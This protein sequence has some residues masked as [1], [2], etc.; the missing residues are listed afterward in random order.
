MKTKKILASSFFAAG[1]AAAFAQYSSPELILVT[2]LGGYDS[3]NTFHA[4]KIDRYDPSTGSYLGSFGNFAN[5]SPTAIT[6]IG[7]DAYVADTFLIGSISYS[8][9][10]KYNFSTGAYDGTIF[11]AGP[12]KIT[13]LATYGGN[14]LA[15]D[16]GVGPGSGGIYTLAPDGSIV[17]ETSA[18]ST[19]QD[20]RI[21]IVGSTAWVT[22]SGN[23][24][25][26]LWEYGLNTNG[27]LGVG[28]GPSGDFNG[29]AA[30]TG[31]TA[32]SLYDSGINSNGYAYIDR[33][34]GSGNVLATYTIPYANYYS[35]SS[36][37]MGHSGGLYAMLY[38]YGYWGVERF[39][40]GN[41][42]AYGPQSYFEIDEYGGSGHT[43]NPGDMA[44]YAAPEP[45]TM[46]GLGLGVLGLIAR[47]RRQR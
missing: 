1:C 12:D 30:G 35:Y 33:R 13:G 45:V 27:T 39:D 40:G 28:G 18:A 8:Q 46:V 5:G 2:D 24:T 34:D 16:N 15:V 29:V 31:A 10:E 26:T 17:G 23:P 19:M 4:P 11:N 3:A 22:A 20:D 38:S 32:G 6:V 21:A 44:V 41:G 9:I 47:R 37:G 43:Y 36:L 42:L 25:G 14:I 7:Q